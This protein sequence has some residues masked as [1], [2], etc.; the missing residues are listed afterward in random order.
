MELLVVHGGGRRPLP[1]IP[2]LSPDASGLERWYPIYISEGWWKVGLCDAVR[3]QTMMGRDLAV[4]S[5]FG[6]CPHS[7]TQ[8][9]SKRK[10]NKLP[11]ST[12]SD[13]NETVLWSVVGAYLVWLD[14]CL[15]LPRKIQ[16]NTYP[17]QREAMTK[18]L[19]L[20]FLCAALAF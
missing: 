3:V 4:I 2:L 17:R 1:D 10:P 20:K 9:H 7:C 19:S 15:R 5:L 14:S 13:F 18:H 11:G 6:G 16:C 8:L 12:K